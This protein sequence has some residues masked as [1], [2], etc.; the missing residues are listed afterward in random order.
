MVA[1]EFSKVLDASNP[2]KFE[3]ETD[4]TDAL[5]RGDFPSDV[6]HRFKKPSYSSSVAAASPQYPVGDNTHTG[7]GTTAVAEQASRPSAS[8][9]Q[10]LS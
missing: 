2:L 9:S 5:M 4:P 10:I 6:Y 8:L 3:Y 7:D 1:E